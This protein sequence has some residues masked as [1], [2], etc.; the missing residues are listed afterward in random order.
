MNDDA[1]VAEATTVITQTV[2]RY[3]EFVREEASLL[4]IA[5]S[6]ALADEDL[7]SSDGDY[8][9]ALPAITPEQEIRRDMAL[10]LLG[11]V[12]GI[13]EVDMYAKW[14]I[15][16]EKPDRVDWRARAQAAEAELERIRSGRFR[17]D[18][19]QVSGVERGPDGTWQDVATGGVLPAVPHLADPQHL[20]GE[21]APA[22]ITVIDRTT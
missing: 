8:L 2:L 22:D 16:G 21:A 18:Q 20:T 15:T 4:A 7:L 14:A 9:E 17:D 3:T 1:V 12:N 6:K 19:V 13:D 5:I 11:P 10:G